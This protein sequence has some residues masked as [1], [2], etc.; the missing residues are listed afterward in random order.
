MFAM[1]FVYINGS[2]G[3]FPRLMR[4][5]YVNDFFIVCFFEWNMWMFL[6]SVD[7]IESV[8]FIVNLCI[9]VTRSVFIYTHSP[10]E[11]YH[12]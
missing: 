9:C 12:Y 3:C 1:S 5:E 2:I 6:E 11:I 7:I 4:I 8:F 10:N